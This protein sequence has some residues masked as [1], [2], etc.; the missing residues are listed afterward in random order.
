[1]VMSQSSVT[2]PKIAGSVTAPMHDKAMAAEF[3]ATL[4]PVAQKFTFQFFGDSSGGYAEVFHGSLDE[5]WPKVQ[6]VNTPARGAGVF[7]TVNETDLRGRRSDNIVRARALW[8]DA[9][10]VDQLD[11]CIG[12]IRSGAMPTMLVQTSVDRAHLYWCC[13]DLSREDFSRYQ[14][15][16]I[17][18]LGTDPAV[19]D[20]P[21]VMRMPGTLHL[22]NP[23]TPSKVTLK[24]PSQP[25]RWKVSDLSRILGLSITPTAGAPAQGNG[26]ANQDAGK[27][28]AQVTSSAD[29]GAWTLP[30][31]F[32][33][34]DA[35]RL[36]RLFEVEG[37]GT[38]DLAAGLVTNIE[39]IR[40]A[41]LAIPTSAISTEL[42]WMHL[43]R[44]LAHEA[45]I[46]PD[47]SEELWEVLDS[48]SRSAP[49]YDQSD[50]RGRWLRY[51]KEA[52]RRDNP[53]RIG[54]VFDLA[55][56]HGWRGWSPK[57]TCKGNGTPPGNR[58]PLQ[59]GKYDPANALALFNS[60]FFIA[61]VAGAAPIA[62]IQE[63]GTIRYLAPRDFSLLV[64]NITVRDTS[65][66]SGE[67]F[68]LEHPERHQ[69]RIVFRP[70]AEDVGPDKYNL[71]QGFG[72]TPVKGF[73]K[74]RRLLRHIFEVICR[75][76]KIKFK[77]L[78]RW[79]AWAVQHPGER[80]ETV[81]VLISRAQGTGKTSLSTVMR[82]I[83]GKHG[84]VISSKQRLLSQFNADLETTC[85]VSGEEML[86]SG[87]KSGHDALK[88][89]ITGDTLTLEVKNG[90]RWDVPNRLHILMT[91][92][93]EHAITAGVHE[94]RH[95]VLEVSDHK[96]QKPEWFD[97]LHRDIADGGREQFL[98]LLQNLQLGDWHPRRLP[99]TAE[100]V[101][102]QRMSADTV[103]QWAS[104]CI[105]ADGIIQPP[106]DWA[107]YSL[108]ST[109]ETNALLT[110][111]SA[112][113]RQHGK[114][115]VD[116]RSFGKKLTAMFGKDARTRLPAGAGSR[117]PWAY[118][119]P[120]AETWRNALD[121][122]LGI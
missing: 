34:G 55:K 109:V 39:E 3:L 99:K 13:D 14:A 57:I 43:A 44:G 31:A 119:V 49:N 24:K 46:Y 53:I 10:D 75:R 103:C 63:D 6:A 16:L 41:V 104:A 45:R 98:W 114:H 117:R 118:A 26:G 19:K 23:S 85:W 74:Q 25:P 112:F 15:A 37:L 27:I 84:R 59:G 68:W 17:E 95:F 28:T 108:P 113:C 42:D 122:Y 35:K 21:R 40:S 78:M 93:H 58:M 71:W 72:V 51:K 90:A 8:V 89:V 111:Y 7:V 2:V 100:A 52:L 48:A 105:E 20:L 11:R 33:P 86:W 102:Q 120:D 92:N 116:Q 18:R 70:G 12:A 97:P 107:R 38:G 88:S 121:K 65:K 94:R 36:R 73:N 83:F 32:T 66:P 5:V 50:N 87:D 54:T 67:K 1:M 4:D 60:H 62:Q 106:D 91:T 69:R 22:K 79:L 80:A 47:Q 81:I 64:R 82:D 115:C 56:K 96:A 110:S 30:A 76:D 77:Y 61:I 9:D 29:T 101:E